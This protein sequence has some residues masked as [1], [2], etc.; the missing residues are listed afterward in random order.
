MACPKCGFHVTDDMIFCPECGTNLRQNIQAQQLNSSL[1]GVTSEQEDVQSNLSGSTNNRKN[2]N[3]SKIFVVL[4]VIVLIIIAYS[5]MSSKGSSKA[6]NSVDNSNQIEENEVFEENNNDGSI[7]NNIENKKPLITDEKIV[8]VVDPSTNLTYDKT[9]AFLMEIENV[10]TD[11]SGNVLVSGKIQ[12]GIININDKV[13]LIGLDKEIKSVDVIGIE[14]DGNNINSAEFGDNVLLTISGVSSDDI[15]IGQAIIQPNSIKSITKYEAHVYLFTK[16]E[17]GRHTPIF[18][19]YRPI[20]RFRTFRL[21]GEFSFS[22]DAIYW[23]GDSLDTTIELEN[24]IPLEVGTEFDVM[25]S[26][27]IVGKGTVVKVY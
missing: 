10:S 21:K 13:H 7:N 19:G 12:R 1:D 9:G 8:G 2:S 18:T 3:F 11:S 14:K 6:N 16:E 22:A 4:I 27:R 23:G 15:Q 25:E 5:F 26:E 24:G 20:I 17:G